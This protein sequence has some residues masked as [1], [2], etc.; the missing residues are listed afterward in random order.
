MLV[1]KS[2]SRIIA[3]VTISRLLVFFL[4]LVFNILFPDHVSTD[5]FVTDVSI[6]NTGLDLVVDSLFSGLNHWDAQYFIHITRYGYDTE[7][8]LAFFPGLPLVLRVPAHVIRILSADLLSTYSAII[9]TGFL[10]NFIFFLL[11]TVMLFELTHILFK[12]SKFAEESVMWFAFNPASIFFSATYSESLFSFLTFTGLLLLENERIIFANVFFAASLMTRSNGLLNTGFT[13]YLILKVMLDSRRSG[14]SKLLFLVIN[15]WSVFLPISLF[16]YYQKVI[17]PTHSC[18]G[19]SFCD[20]NTQSIW[21]LP[22]FAIQKKYWSQGF[23][24][25]W[26][27]KQSLNFMMGTPIIAVCLWSAGTYFLRIKDLLLN[28]KAYIKEHRFWTHPRLVPY[29]VHIS[30]LS[31]TALF[32]M[33]VQV[34]VRLLSSSSPWIYWL[35]ACL[36]TYSLSHKVIKNL[37]MTYFLLGIAL[38]SNNMPFT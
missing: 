24:R 26:Q 17:I 27:L 8:K 22:Y 34:A 1:R 7:E 16:C 30:F 32:F 23:L 20:E 29:A 21:L 9:V 37:F 18:P 35:A 10:F 28:A 36:P 15:L 19:M 11:A 3:I 33:H 31:L 6:N 38:F 14:F 4:Q 25:F 5:A 2:A 13:L 12:E